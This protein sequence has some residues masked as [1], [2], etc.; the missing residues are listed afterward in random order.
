MTL[1]S[2]TVEIYL[3]QL[4]CVSIMLIICVPFI[5]VTVCNLYILVIYTSEFNI[6]I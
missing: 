3:S 5:V 6:V 4:E 1:M 2:I